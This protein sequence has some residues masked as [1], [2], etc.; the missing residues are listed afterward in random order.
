MA[1]ILAHKL[2]RQAYELCQAI[3]KFPASDHQTNTVMKAAKL[4]D[5]IAELTDLR[6]S[7]VAAY[8]MQVADGRQASDGRV[9]FVRREPNVLVLVDG[10]EVACIPNNCWVSDV[11]NMTAY[12]ERE[13]DWNTFMLHHTGQQDMLKG[14]R[15]G[16]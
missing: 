7:G 9:T 15:G 12:G 5:A 1:D 10:I 14:R 3:E 16:W 13:G 8:Q 6:G 11:L 2:I 4:M